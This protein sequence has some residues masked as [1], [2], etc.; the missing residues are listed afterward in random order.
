MKPPRD[1]TVLAIDDSQEILGTIRTFLKDQGYHVRT[2]TEP[3]RAIQLAQ[4]GNIDLIL[5][6]IRMPQMD[7]YAVSNALKRDPR[8]REIPVI[9][10]TA[11]EVIRR[12]P[13]NFF[14]GLYGFLAKPFSKAELRKSVSRALHLIHPGEKQ[15]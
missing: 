7:G 13:R 5:L 11:K 14:Y 6:D 4:R 8:T 2:S 3:A 1:C 10:M 9:M 12:T 15:G